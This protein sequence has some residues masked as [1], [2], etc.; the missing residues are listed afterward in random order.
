MTV[1]MSPELSCFALRAR[2]EAQQPDG[3]RTTV[4][5]K[6]AVKVTLNR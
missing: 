4:S 1:W 5:E 3:S 6:Q 2:I